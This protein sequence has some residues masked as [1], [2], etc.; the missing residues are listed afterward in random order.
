MLLGR[1]LDQCRSLAAGSTR[2]DLMAGL[3]VGFGLGRAHPLLETEAKKK[4][5][6]KANPNEYG[7][8]EVGDRCKTADEC[9]WGF[10]KAGSA[11]RTAPI[12]A[13]RTLRAYAW[14]GPTKFHPW[15]VARI[16]GASAPPP[17]A[18]SV[19][20][21]LAPL[22][23]STAP[24][25]ERTLT[26]SRWAT[27]P[28]QIAPTWDVATAPDCVTPAWPAWFPVAL[29][30]LSRCREPMEPA[31]TGSMARI[32]RGGHSWTACSSNN[33]CEPWRRLGGHT[34]AV[35]SHWARSWRGSRLPAR[36][37]AAESAGQ[38]SGSPMPTAA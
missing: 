32:H 31:D 3:A 7:C 28:A 30:L 29:N 5:K 23:P 38:R 21:V 26:A 19:A 33:S 18:T 2:R 8:L 14:Q 10:V 9:C 27:Q 24:P 1:F 37:S 11:A 36:K 35:P 34:W 25:A 15:A 17:A 13:G 22:L 6:K 12:S 4:R 16:A 20:R